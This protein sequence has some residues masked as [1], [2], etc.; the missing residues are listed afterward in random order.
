MDNLLQVLPSSTNCRAT[1]RIVKRRNVTPA[2]DGSGE[3]V[4]PDNFHALNDAEQSAILSR[5]GTP[6][7]TIVATSRPTRNGN[8]LLLN[9]SCQYASKNVHT[10]RARAKSFKPNIGMIT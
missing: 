2:R 8:T 5:G 6:Y 1:A 3:F 9:L 10:G 4:Q 7:V